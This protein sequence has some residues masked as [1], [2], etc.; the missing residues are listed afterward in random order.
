MAEARG[1]YANPEKSE[2]LPLAAVASGL[3]MTQRTK[4]TVRPVFNCPVLEKAI[5][6]EIIVIIGG[7]SAV[8]SINYC[9]SHRHSYKRQYQVFVQKSAT[10]MRYGA[11]CLHWKLSE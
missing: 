8:D 4:D 11:C 5:P 6:L 1:Q 10:V 2:R 7:Q 3:E 9:Y